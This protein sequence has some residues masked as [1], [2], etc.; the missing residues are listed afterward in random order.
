MVKLVLPMILSGVLAV[1]P[2]HAGEDLSFEVASVKPAQRPPGMRLAGC[3]GGPGTPDPTTWSCRYTN[4]KGLLFDAYDLDLYQYTE[5]SWMDNA[6]FEVVAKVPP[7][8]TKDQFQKMQQHLLEGRFKLALHWEPRERT[9]YRLLVAKTGLKMHESPP[10]SP[11]P[12]TEWGRAPGSTIGTDH[13]PLF[14]DGVSGLMGLNNYWHWR[15]S[16]VSLPILTNE[17]RHHVR[18][19]VIDATALTGKYDIDITFQERPIEDL[20]YAPPFVN[21]IEKAIQERLGL[22][23][24]TKKGT[25]SVPVIDHIEKT[26]TTN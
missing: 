9:V 8:T 20:P 2:V 6:W 22:R 15:S 19:D 26:P 1:F 14:P 5:P 25:I 24:E 7:G 3:T 4:V 17:L 18:S 23:V 13:Y 11:D 21:P 12:V 16:N 10:G